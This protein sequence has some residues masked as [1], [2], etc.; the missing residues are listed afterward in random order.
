MPEEIQIVASP[1]QWKDEFQVNTLDPVRDSRWDRFVHNHPRGSIFHTSRWLEALHQTYGYEPIAFVTSVE[2]ALTGALVSCRV[3]SWLTG[4]RLVSL[5]FSDH[6]EP[7]VDDHAQFEVLAEVLE[8][9]AGTSGCNYAEFRPLTAIDGDVQKRMRIGQSELFYIHRLEL[10]DPLEVLFRRLHKSCIQRKIAKAERVGLTYEEGRSDELLAKFYSLLL[11]T[12][13]R[14][15]LPPQ[16]LAWFR[17]LT[18]YMGESLKIR[19]ALQHGSPVASI[20]T[21]HFG[22]THVYKYGCSDARCHD[23]GAM[24]WLMWNAIQDAHYAGAHTFDFGRSEYDNEGLVAFKDRWGSTKEALTYYRFP[25][26]ETSKSVCR[27]RIRLVS[28][29]CSYL[30]DRAFASV[31]RLLYR[32]VG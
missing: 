1:K 18:T 27:G 3:K 13:R 15:Q 19:V 2:T 25:R 6:C 8:H 22:R 7:L 10:R 26:P 12:R 14:H 17:N 11:L 32:H 16:P 29:I 21:L 4:S 9:Q 28:T 30:P 5:P 23:L 31:G 20:I 24:P